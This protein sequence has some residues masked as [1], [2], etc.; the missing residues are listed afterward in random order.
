MRTMEAV[1]VARNPV[2]VLHFVEK[3]RQTVLVLKAGTPHCRIQPVSKT[4]TQM[5]AVLYRRTAKKRQHHKN[6]A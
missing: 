5:F 4:E 3:Y 6:R 2:D 1:E